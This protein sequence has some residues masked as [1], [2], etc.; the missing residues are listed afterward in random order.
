MRIVLGAT[1]QVGSM[2]VVELLNKNEK[3]RAIIRDKEKAAPLKKMG[4]DVFVANYT[5]VHALKTAFDGCDSAFLIT[6][7]NPFSEDC[8]LEASTMLGSYKEAILSSGVSEVI[9]LS[10]MGAQHNSGTGNLTISNKFENLFTDTKVKTSFIRPAYYFSNWAGYINMVQENGFLPSFFPAQ[11]K[12]PMIAPY[13]VACFV[14]GV[15]TGVIEHKPLFEIYNNYYCADDIAD[16]MGDLLNK[17]VTVAAIPQ[18]EWFNSLKQVGFTDSGASN[19][20]LMTEA[21]VTGKTKPETE[22]IKLPT[23]FRRYI[24]ELIQ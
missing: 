7:E 20:A 19:L 22:L 6:P 10:S 12:I 16:A 9:G 8:I 24:S 3:V 21:V 23:E 15:I 14:A 1:G 11:L 13:D 2:L 4:V 5:D 17:D 18:N